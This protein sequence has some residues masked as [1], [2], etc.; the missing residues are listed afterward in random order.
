VLFLNQKSLINLI[1]AIALIL[2]LISGYFKW[3]DFKEKRD[4]KQ[5]DLFYLLHKYANES[6]DNIK[7]IKLQPP[8]DLVCITEEDK[9]R[10]IN[11]LLLLESKLINKTKI[12]DNNSFEVPNN[13]CDVYIAPKGFYPKSAIK[14]FDYY[15]IYDGYSY[16]FETSSISVFN[17]IFDSVSTP[18]TLKEFSDFSKRTDTQI[19]NTSENTGQIEEL[20]KDFKGLITKSLDIQYGTSNIVLTEVF[21]NEF[22][23]KI[24]GISAFYKKELKPYKII[25]I[26]YYETKDISAGHLVVYVRVEDTEGEYAQIVHLVKKN[27][28]FAI[29][30]IEYDI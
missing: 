25:S 27:G 20:T 21:T 23:N 10:T 22:V 1:T 18:I 29:D 3:S 11:S 6:V 4:I 30:D 13:R 19:N 5:S 15:I 28:I 26:N 17:E 8:G 24:E 7:L 9:M 14:M 2:T 12:T 16:N